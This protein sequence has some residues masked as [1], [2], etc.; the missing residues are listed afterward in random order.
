MANLRSPHYPQLNLADAIDKARKVYAAEHTHKA[1]KEVVAKS[2][3]YGTLNGKSIGLIAT[4]KKY[5]LLQE[6]KDGLKITEDAVSIFELPEGEPERA[7]AIKRLAFKPQLF[8]DLHGAFGD[9]LPSDVNLRHYLIKRKFLPKA[10]EEVIR[11]YRDNLE[12]VTKEAGSYNANEQ[13]SSKAHAQEEE[14][15]VQQPPP[16]KG[17]PTPEMQRMFASKTAADLSALGIPVPQPGQKEL[18]FNISRNSQA[19]VIFTGDVTQEAIEKLAALLELQKDTFPTKAELQ[20]SEQQ[21]ISEDYVSAGHGGRRFRPELL[22]P[23][24]PDQE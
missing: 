11:I 22:D 3:G 16:F 9:N 21:D 18:Q 1:P 14:T 24:L 12:L 6:E 4:L 17:H 20:H 15:P 2:L 13:E 8:S 23:D 10:A 19:R 7:A 5:G